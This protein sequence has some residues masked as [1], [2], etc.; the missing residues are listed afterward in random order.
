VSRRSQAKQARRKKRQATRN[1]AWLPDAAHQEL[2][3]R[4]DDVIG[5]LEEF[6]ARLTERGWVFNEDLDDDAG[7]LWYWPP[8]LAETDDSEDFSTATVV[9]LAEAEGGE[10]AHVVFV[11]SELDHQFALDELFDHLDTVEAYRLGDPLPTF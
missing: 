7:V 10:I 8:S 3:D 5:G 1:A 2:S 4:L 6:D 11:G 9:A